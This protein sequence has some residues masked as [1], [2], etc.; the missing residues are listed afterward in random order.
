MSQWSEKLVDP[1]DIRIKIA[2]IG[3]RIIVRDDSVSLLGSLDIL[4]SEEKRTTAVQVSLVCRIHILVCVRKLRDSGESGDTL[5]IIDSE[6]RLAY[7]T[8]LSLDDDDTVGAT[9]TIDSSCRC[10]FEDSEALD[11]LRVDIVE[12]TLNTIDKHERSGRLIRKGRNTTDPDVGLIVTRL[13]CP[14][15][16]DNACESSGDN[17]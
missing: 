16:R 5:V 2:V 7:P 1:V 4:R 10:I 6:L 12:A 14:L 11:I 13:A 17:R 9:Y 8:R 15:D 3:L